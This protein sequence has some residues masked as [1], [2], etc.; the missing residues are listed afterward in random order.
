L[1]LCAREMQEVVENHEFITKLKC[2]ALPIEA[3]RSNA[4]FKSDIYAL[5]SERRRGRNAEKKNNSEM[6]QNYWV[7]FSI[8]LIYEY[9]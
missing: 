9:F 5:F 7:R 3:Y 8:M 4:K 2:I 1:E 6:L